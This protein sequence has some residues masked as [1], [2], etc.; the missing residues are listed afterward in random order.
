[1]K[2]N[3]GRCCTQVSGWELRRQCVIPAGSA[4]ESRRTLPCRHSRL[5]VDVCVKAREIA[6]LA[7]GTLLQQ[8]KPVA[9]ALDAT[10]VDMRFV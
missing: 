1:M 3:V 2:T 6:I 5:A 7:F 8:A 10:L 4:P 9:D